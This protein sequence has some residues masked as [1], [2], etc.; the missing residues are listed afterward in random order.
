MTLGIQAAISGLTNPETA[1][2]ELTVINKI[3]DTL[4]N[5]P[6]PMFSPI[7]PLTLRD[8]RAAPMRVKIKAEAIDAKRLWYSISND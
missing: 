1:K 7:P 5:N 4:S 2:V 3:Y 8:D 6:I